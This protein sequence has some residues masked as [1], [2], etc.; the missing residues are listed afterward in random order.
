MTFEQKIKRLEEI[1]ELMDDSETP[2][3]E[4]IE[5]YEEGMKL[6]EQARKFLDD[7][8]QKILDISSKKEFDIAE[9]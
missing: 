4:L 6:S 9:N 1:A 7:A 2:V 8:E 5:L 3:E